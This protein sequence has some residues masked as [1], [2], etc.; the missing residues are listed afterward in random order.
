M[1]I[2]SGP[3]ESVLSGVPGPGEGLPFSQR[4]IRA[5]TECGVVQPPEDTFGTSK[6]RVWAGRESRTDNNACFPINLGLIPLVSLSISRTLRL[7]SPMR[8]SAIQS[9]PERYLGGGFR[10]H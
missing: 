3:G 2:S 8:T 7:L 6:A 1:G 5:G 10:T 4:L 9:G